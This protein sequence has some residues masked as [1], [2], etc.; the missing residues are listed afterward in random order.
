MKIVYECASCELRTCDFR[1]RP[2]DEAAK[3]GEVIGC[4]LEFVAAREHPNSRL[5]QWNTLK[6]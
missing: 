2:R 5:W 6:K 4:E 1:L 3:K